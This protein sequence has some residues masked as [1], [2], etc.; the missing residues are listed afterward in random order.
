MSTVLVTQIGRVGL[1]TLNRPEALNALNAELLAD[2]LA[3]AVAFD[4]SPDV[5]C[6]VLTGSERAFAA[7]ADVKEMVGRTAAQ[8]IE[9][10][11]MSG[12]DDFA[13]LGIPK[14]AAV[15]GLALGGGCELAMMCDTIFAAD[16]AT[17]G[18]PELKL[19]LIPGLGATQRLTRAIGKARAMDVILTGRTFSA[20]EAFAWG[21]VARVVPSER[22]LDEA[23]EAAAAIAGYSAPVVRS[24]RRLVA[25]A[26]EL[27]LADGISAERADFYRT[28]DLD[29]AK[30]GIG[31][32]TEK[33]PPQFR[34]R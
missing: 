27:P 23:L 20:A 5:G 1:I 19:G 8:N 14:I 30:E 17:F 29:D 26:F 25:E 24:A 34:H 4:S 3:A 11:W 28:F 13:A 22:V 31:S 33:R 7:G 15:R 21:L 2:V 18:Q 16:N 32:F 12:W 6:L 10:Q 9:E